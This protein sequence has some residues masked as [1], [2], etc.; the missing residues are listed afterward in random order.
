MGFMNVVGSLTSCYAAT[1]E[2]AL[3]DSNF[4]SASDPL[5]EILFKLNKG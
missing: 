5:L 4:K 2:L 1:G 3:F